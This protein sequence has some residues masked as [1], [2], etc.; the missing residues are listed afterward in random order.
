MTA[1]TID[2]EN[3]ITVFA[4]LKEIQGS[5]EGTET[6]T[7]QE[8][9]AALADKWAGGRL[10]EVWNSLPGVQPVERFTGRRV[11]VRRIW[12]AIQHLEV[13]R[14]ASNKPA[15]GVPCP[16]KQSEVHVRL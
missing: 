11:A 10:V 2:S 9:F 14:A 16:L 4:S 3:N 6:F 12:K 15:T 1:F 13:E 5:E 7:N 8:E